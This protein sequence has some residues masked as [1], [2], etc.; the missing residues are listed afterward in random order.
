MIRRP[1]RST[2]FP[3]TTLFRSV[4]REGLPEVG[5]VVVPDAGQVQHLAVLLRAEPHDLLLARQVDAEEEAVIDPQ[6]A[7]G[8]RR[9]VAVEEPVRFVPAADLGVTDRRRAAEQAQL[10]EAHARGDPDREGA[11]DYFQVELAPV[12]CPDLVEA[13]VKGCDRAGEDVEPPRGALA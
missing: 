6:L 10:V 11:R 12:A 5:G 9:D 4:P 1:P 7:V 13:G 8:E 2:L 3:Y